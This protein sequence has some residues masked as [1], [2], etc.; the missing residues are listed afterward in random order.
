MKREIAWCVEQCLTWRKVKA[1]HQRPHGKMHP[2]T[3]SHVEI[4]GYHYGVY[5]KIAKDDM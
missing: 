1:E 5:Y 4:G 2:F 3:H